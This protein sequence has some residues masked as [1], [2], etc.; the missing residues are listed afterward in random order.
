MFRIRTS[1]YTIFTFLPKNL[2]EQF[3][4]VANTFFLLLVILQAFPEYETVPIGVAAMPIIV[5][6]SMTAIK[7]GFED[8]K[9]WVSDKTVNERTSLVLRGSW[10]NLNYRSQASKTFLQKVV[11]WTQ[12]WAFCNS[13]SS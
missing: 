6:V 13:I 4:R 8:Y 3:R 2:F 11:R 5:I 10:R 7:D 1:K 9:R 12:K